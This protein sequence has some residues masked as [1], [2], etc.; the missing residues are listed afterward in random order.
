[1][2]VM[3]TW[4]VCDVPLVPEW[5]P[6]RFY[7]LMLEACHPTPPVHA[8]TPTNSHR[9]KA[10]TTCMLSTAWLLLVDNATPSAERK[11]LMG[12]SKSGAPKLRCP[13]AQLGESFVVC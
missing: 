10:V 9:I 5:R 6:S 7:G 13:A 8:V 1:M 11:S 3:Q 2:N 12:V 4:H